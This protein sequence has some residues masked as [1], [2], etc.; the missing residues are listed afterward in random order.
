[1]SEVLEALPVEAVPPPP[2]PAPA[3][4]WSAITRL[5]F[6]FA[7]CYFTL[8]ALC[9]GNATLWEILPFGAGD[10]ISS[11]LAWP[12]NHAAEWVGQNLL[13]L[14]GT[15]SKLHGGG[16]GDKALDWLAGGLM[17][18]LALLL[19]FLWTLRAETR[20]AATRSLAYPRTL[21]WFH[22]LLRL[23]LGYAMLNYGMVKV[24][25]LQMG[26]PLLATLNAPLGHTSPMTM[27][28][29]LIGLNPVYETIC[30]L[31]EVAAGILIVFRRTAL[32]GTLLTAFLSTNIVLY[33]FCYDVPVKLYALHLLLMSLVL[34]VPATPVLF[35]FFFLHRPVTPRERWTK[36]AGRLRIQVETLVIVIVLVL[37]LGQ[38]IAQ[39]APLSMTMARSIANP[40]VWTGQWH[41]DSAILKGAPFAYATGDGQPMTDLFLEPSGRATVRDAATVLWRA[42]TQFDDK[43]HT[44]KLS[45]TGHPGSAEYAIAQ[46]DPTHLL[47][48]PTG[49]DAKTEP[50]LALSR[51]PLPRSYPLLDRGFHFINEWGLER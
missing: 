5:G 10:F 30:G 49:K 24:F 1:M 3:P 4:R 20:P 46:P 2:V 38:G 26:P 34:L 9:C 36:P 42:R 43:K 13:H 48:T 31:A 21:L 25:P 35:G 7:V 15:G 17:L 27:L 50:I 44:V 45:C 51:V 28:W 6:R 22:L 19:T 40:S 37:I 18:A 32:L 16:S 41:L 23:A 47:L 12:F 14:T 8:F 39:L 33:N 11:S 29:T